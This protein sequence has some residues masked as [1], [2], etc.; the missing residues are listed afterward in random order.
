MNASRFI[1]MFIFWVSVE[2]SEPLAS[3][4]PVS[5]SELSSSTDQGS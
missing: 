1:E 5:V 3:A 4:V 2:V